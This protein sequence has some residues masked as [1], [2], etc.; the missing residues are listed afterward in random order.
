MKAEFYVVLNITLCKALDYKPALSVIR[1][2]IQSN[3]FMMSF[4][5]A[6]A[7]NKKLLLNFLKLIDGTFYI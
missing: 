5:M 4:S 2:V 3:V 1:C 6:W 7:K